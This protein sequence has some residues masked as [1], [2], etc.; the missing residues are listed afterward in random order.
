MI[1]SAPPLN[2]FWKVQDG[3]QR[4]LIQQVWRR[5]PAHDRAVLRSLV[6]EVSQA[7]EHEDHLGVAEV[8]DPSCPAGNAGQ[9]AIDQYPAVHLFGLDAVPDVVALFVI[10]HEF[11]HVVLRHHQMRTVAGYLQGF[12]PT[13]IYTNA[14]LAS[15]SSWHEDAADLLAYSWG[16]AAEMAAFLDYY[17]QARRS[18]WYVELEFEEA[19]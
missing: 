5:L 14:E 19:T 9:I 16:F 1:R 2:F 13:P 4:W 10:A 3:H 17:P 12:E 6:L 8:L 15:L 18:R 11:A 7:P